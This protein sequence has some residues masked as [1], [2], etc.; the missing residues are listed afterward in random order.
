MIAKMLMCATAVWMIGA[1][2]LAAQ[3]NP[4]TGIDCSRPPFA[5]PPFPERIVRI[6]VGYYLKDPNNTIVG[7][8][9]GRC[10]QSQSAVYI[11]GVGARRNSTGYIDRARTFFGLYTPLSDPPEFRVLAIDKKAEAE[12]TNRVLGSG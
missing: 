7:R 5:L 10:D 1:T 9:V 6:G 11:C 2:N 4:R 12:C 8:T 3:V